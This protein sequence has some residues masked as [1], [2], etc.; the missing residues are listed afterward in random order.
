MI[1]PGAGIANRTLFRLGQELPGCAL[2]HFAKRLLIATREEPH[3]SAEDL[4]QRGVSAVEGNV[5]A[6]VAVEPD[7]RHAPLDPPA[8]TVERRRR[9]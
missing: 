1:D 5:T 4:V 7:V 2:R 8:R 9:R 3:A 6:L